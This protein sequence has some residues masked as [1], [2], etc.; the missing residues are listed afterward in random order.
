MILPA[1][2]FLTLGLMLGF[3]N[4][5]SLR[6]KRIEKH[7]LVAKYFRNQSRFDRE[8]PKEVVETKVE[9]AE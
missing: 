4:N 9:E 1:G 3:F 2:A 8:K 7:E 6:R 5:L